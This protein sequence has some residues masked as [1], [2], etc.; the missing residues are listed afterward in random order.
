MNMSSLVHLLKVVSSTPSLG[1]DGARSTRTVRL[2]RTSALTPVIC[3]QYIHADSACTGVARITATTT[4]SMPFESRPIRVFC[5]FNKTSLRAKN[6]WPYKK[7]FSNS[8]NASQISYSVTLLRLEMSYIIVRAMVAA[9]GC[10]PFPVL[11]TTFS[12]SWASP[13]SPHIVARGGRA[14]VDSSTSR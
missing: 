9:F 7:Y 5:I 1:L 3:N 8:K 10:S 4:L 6:I 2:P 14:V 11:P 12:A 13:R